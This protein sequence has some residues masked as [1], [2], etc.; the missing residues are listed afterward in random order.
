MGIYLCR[1][2]NPSFGELTQHTRSTQREQAKKK[3]IDGLTLCSLESL[4]DGTSR[5]HGRAIDAP[6]EEEH[7]KHGYVKG[8]QCR[9]DHVAGIIC[10][11][12]GPRTYERTG[13]WRCRQQWH[14]RRRSCGGAGRS[15]R[16]ECLVVHDVVSEVH[17]VRRRRRWYIWL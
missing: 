2:R 3:R 8:A 13:R 7:D 6:V 16:D 10:Q 12:A 17:R 9:V 15:H 14:G 4:I 11:L 1:C 5:P